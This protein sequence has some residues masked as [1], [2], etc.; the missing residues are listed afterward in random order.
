MTYPTIIMHYWDR[1]MT[2]TVQ[3]Q[4][5]NLRKGLTPKHQAGTCM[6]VATPIQ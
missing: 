1:Q 2:V 5:K 6:R 3:K 4:L